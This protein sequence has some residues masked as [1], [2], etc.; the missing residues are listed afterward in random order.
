MFRK[1]KIAAIRFIR[2]LVIK[3]HPIEDNEPSAY[4]ATVARFINALR[5]FFYKIEMHI[6]QSCY[7]Q[8]RITKHATRSLILSGW[9]SGNK[10][11]TELVLNSWFVSYG[12]SNR[13]ER[14]MK[15]KQIRSETID[16]GPIRFTMKQAR[17]SVS[18]QI[19]VNPRNWGILILPN[20]YT[21]QRQ[22]IYLHDGRGNFTSHFIRS[23]SA[24]ENNFNLNWKE[25]QRGYIFLMETKR[26]I[27]VELD[28]CS[29]SFE[30]RKTTWLFI[31]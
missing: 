22:S 30:R 26:T 21:M 2:S 18:T 19:G 13:I 28:F 31:Y 17:C 24:L 14:R 4:F 8:A 10:D 9:L 27:L 15:W 12:V 23:V 11:Y 16:G 7:F 29:Q 6:R 3:M 5:D 1:I 25:N 20:R